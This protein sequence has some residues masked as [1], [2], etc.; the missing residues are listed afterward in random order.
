MAGEIQRERAFGNV[1]TSN[2]RLRSPSGGSVKE[3]KAPTLASLRET[4]YNENTATQDADVLATRSTD[5]ANTVTDDAAEAPAITQD[6]GDLGARV[7][8]MLSIFED[9][10]EDEANDNSTEAAL[11]ALPVP[12]DDELTLED[13]SNKVVDVAKD[14]ITFKEIT[15]FQLKALA[16]RHLSQ[17]EFDIYFSRNVDDGDFDMRAA[18]LA[19]L[20]FVFAPRDCLDAKREII[21]AKLQLIATR[22]PADIRDDLLDGGLVFEYADDIF[23]YLKEA[24]VGFHQQHSFLQPTNILL[25]RST[26]QTMI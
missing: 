17:E 11:V 6:A 4:Y 2:R 13:E 5:G 9:P 18:Y 26:P 23:Q 22:T 21:H 25:S 19:K 24:E 15:Y 1:K 12:A 3:F 20:P 10:L 16:G 7:T 14:D 8:T